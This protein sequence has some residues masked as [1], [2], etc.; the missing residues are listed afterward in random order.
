MQKCWGLTDSLH[1]KY[2]VETR[3]PNLVT[4]IAEGDASAMPQASLVLTGACSGADEAFAVEALKS[5]HGV[6]HFLGPED[7]E[8][9]SDECKA[10]QSQ[11][12][13][14]LSNETLTSDVCEKAFQLAA[15]SRIR[16]SQRKDGWEADVAAMAA[17]RNYFQVRMAQ[18][19]YVVSWRCGERADPYAGKTEVPEG[20]TPKLDIGGGTGWACQWYADRFGPGKEDPAN[21]QLYFFDDA[22]P[23]WARTGAPTSKR[24]SRWDAVG[25]Q[26]VPMTSPPPRPTGVYAGIGGTRISAEA[27]VAI[28]NLFRS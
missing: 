17:R 5:G 26:W 8:W 9:A 3:Y 25:Q 21:C 28:A 6:V 27:R 22:G 2:A 19:V 7:E 20:E 1:A 10:N 16:G 12:F 14:R 13:H 4:A 23:P 24:W 11:Y 15:M 18:A